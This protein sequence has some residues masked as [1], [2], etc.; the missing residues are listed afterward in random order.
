VQTY[1]DL[2]R[3]GA[4]GPEPDELLEISGPADLLPGNRAMYGD[5]VSLDVREDAFVGCRSTA[6]VVLGLKPVD[7]HDNREP[8]DC[9]P[10]PGDSSYRARDELYMD[11][12][13]RQQ[14]Q[15]RVQLA[16]PDERLAADD[17]HV[18][19]TM[20]VDQREHTVDQFL[21]LE[22]PKTAERDVAAEM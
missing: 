2:L 21:T 18:Q 10:L 17:R 1:P 3:L 11:T 15:Q 5:P 7:R 12:P 4:I 6:D 16:V 19:R 14:R 13:F 8:R 20:V 22:I 9:A